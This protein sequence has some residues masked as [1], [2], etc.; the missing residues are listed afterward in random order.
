MPDASNDTEEVFLSLDDDEPE[1]VKEKK[2]KTKLS[3]Q[4]PSTA[5]SESPSQNITVLDAEILDT[6]VIKEFRG[7][8]EVA[9]PLLG[10]R[11]EP[12]VHIVILDFRF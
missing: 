10:S 9:W 7:T 4:K 11:A 8:F 5:T 3:Q 6:T 12:G 1:V 2:K